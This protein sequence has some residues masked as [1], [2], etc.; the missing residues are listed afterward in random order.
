MKKVKTWLKEHKKEIIVGAVA[1]GGTAL[2]FFAN[3]KKV[4]VKA[5]LN[6]TLRFLDGID[7]D[8]EYYGCRTLSD[9]YTNINLN[10]PDLSISD[11][12]KLG[13][14]LKEKLPAIAKDTKINY[15]SANYSQFNKKVG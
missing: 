3:Q 8:D 7:N 1:A 9:V 11:C 5:G 10:K 12:G 15:L 4:G 6:L 2:Y 13:E 14:V